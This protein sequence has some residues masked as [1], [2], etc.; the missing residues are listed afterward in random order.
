VSLIPYPLRAAKLSLE[1][2]P[3]SFWLWP[4]MRV[5]KLSESA[6]ESGD[7]IWWFRWMWFQVS[8][9]RWL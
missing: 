4:S 2:A 5:R 3:F 6:K 7:R 9:S 1:I 8:Y